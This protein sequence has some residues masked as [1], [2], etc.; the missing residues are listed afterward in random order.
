MP[1]PMPRRRAGHD[2][3]PSGLAAPSRAER[4]VTCAVLVGD[5]DARQ[6]EPQ[7][8]WVRAVNDGS[9][10][11]I[12]ER[13]SLPFERDRLLGEAR[14]RLG[15]GTTAAPPTSATTTS[16]SR[17]T[18]CCPR[19]RTKPSSPCSAAGSTRR[20]LLRLLEVRLQ[21]ASTSRADPGVATRRS[22]ADRS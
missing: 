11:P 6:P 13:P 7:P 18:C 1:R 20:F 15:A 8:E 22:R 16:S 21:L 10:S 5:P 14:A 12:A 17:S 2:H 3:D 9:I 4:N 19:S